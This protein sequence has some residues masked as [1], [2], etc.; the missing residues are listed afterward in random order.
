MPIKSILPIFAQYSSKPS[1]TMYLS[2]CILNLVIVWFPA[3]HKTIQHCDKLATQIVAAVRLLWSGGGTP[4]FT[5]REAEV[6]IET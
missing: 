3:E 2:K 1:L 4:W 6:L 5:A